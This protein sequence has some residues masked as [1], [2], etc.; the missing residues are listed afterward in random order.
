MTR[1]IGLDPSPPVNPSHGCGWVWLGNL[2]DSS[3]QNDVTAD[4]S[5]ASMHLGDTAD[6]HEKG[7]SKLNNCPPPERIPAGSN[8]HCSHGTAIYVTAAGGVDVCADVGLERDG[9]T[10]GCTDPLLDERGDPVHMPKD[11]CVEWRYVTGD[12]NWFMVKLRT[13]NNPTASWVFIPRTASSYRDSRLPN[14][15][16]KGRAQC[17]YWLGPRWPR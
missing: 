12:D 4:S 1:G 11:T 15:L 2:D 10:H 16:T 9:D 8:A 7:F 13:R 5:Q 3:V 6:T 17:P 14:I